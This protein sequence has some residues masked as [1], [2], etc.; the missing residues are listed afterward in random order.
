[1]LNFKKYVYGLLLLFSW[2]TLAGSD[3]NLPELEASYKQ[4]WQL[5]D[6]FETS[7]AL[8]L[9]DSLIQEMEE[10]GQSD[11]LLYWWIKYEKGEILEICNKNEEALSLYYEVVRNAEQARKW[12]LVAETYI[13]IARIH[14]A[15]GRQEDCLRNLTIARQIIQKHQL[16][17]VSS[18]YAIRYASYHR[19][20]DNRDSAR[21]YATKAVVSGKQYGVQRSELDGHLLMG[22]VTDNIDES[23]YHFEEA[24]KISLDRKSYFS[25]ALQQLNITDRYLKTG[26][27]EKADSSLNLSY[28]FAKNIPENYPGY[29]TAYSRLHNSKRILFEQ[30]GMIDSAYFYFRKSIEAGKLSSPLINQ[31]A[32]SQQETAFAIEKEQDKL[33]FEKQRSFYMRW[34]LLLM[35]LLLIAMAAGHFNNERKKRFIAKQTD[36]ISKK[37]RN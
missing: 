10:M 14:E 16:N 15:I 32:I 5:V 36:L 27:L 7:T 33:R 1:M 21:I 17:A 3:C 19:I 13:S 9:A 34:G 6:A 18:R 12:E 37:M 30:L 8:P 29:Y 24:V 20:Y 11:C 23:I 31:D 28:A 4:L 26:N 25:A 35:G 2:S 22:I